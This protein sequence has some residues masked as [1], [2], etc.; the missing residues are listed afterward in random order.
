MPTVP[1]RSFAT[2]RLRFGQSIKVINSSGGQVVDFWAFSLPST[3]S[4]PRYMSMTHTR[5]TLHKFLPSLQE[6]FLDNRRDPILTVTEDASPGIHDVLYAACSPERYLQLGASIEHDNCADNLFKAVKKIDDPSFQYLVEFL[7][8]G[9]MPDPLN[10][11]MNVAVD[12]NKLTCLIPGSKAGDFITLRAEQ[13]CI[14][15]MSACP[16]DVSACNEGEPTSIDFQVL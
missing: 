12:K 15:V 5:S 4:F 13:D 2:Q 16:M 11:F 7:E 9:W 1:A 3:I 10:L 8:H 6:S 14:V